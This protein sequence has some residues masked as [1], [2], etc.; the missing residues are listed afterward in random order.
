MARQSL[1]ASP[2]GIATLKTTLKR[3]KWSQEH[4]A[5]AAGCSRQTIWSL[6]RGNAIDAEFFFNVCTQLE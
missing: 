6:L 5:G 3:K 4:L 2:E 1:R